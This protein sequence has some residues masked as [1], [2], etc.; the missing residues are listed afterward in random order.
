MLH[1][2]PKHWY[3]TYLTT[4]LYLPLHEMLR[5]EEKLE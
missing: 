2:L 1:P 5:S 3:Y 4:N